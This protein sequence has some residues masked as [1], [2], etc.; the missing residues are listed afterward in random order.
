MKPLEKIDKLEAKR[1]MSFLRERVAF[2]PKALGGQL[3]GE[4]RVLALA[5]WRLQNPGED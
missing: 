4:L 5:S 2:D 1:I 3:K